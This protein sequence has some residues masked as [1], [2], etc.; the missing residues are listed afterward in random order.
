MRSATDFLP[1]FM[2]TF[3]NLASISLLYFG[4]GRMVR[5]GAAARRDMAYLPSGKRLLLR[6]LGAV[7]GT[8]LLAVVDAGAVEG[9]ADGVVAHAGQV[10]HAAAADQ[11]HR[12][13]LQVVA[14]A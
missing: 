7:L 5:A 9:A 14:L 13:L 3:M 1:S 10:L 11:H 6:T 8:A 2:T 4:S 12:V